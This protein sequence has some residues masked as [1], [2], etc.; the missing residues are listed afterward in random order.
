MLQGLSGVGWLALVSG[1]TLKSSDR[2]ELLEAKNREALGGGGPE[3]IARQHERGKLT[4]RER[5]EL[6]LDP[7]SFVELDR[8]VVHQCDDFGMERNKS[9]GDG[10]ISGYGSVDGRKVFVYSQDFT[11]LGG[12]LGA[13]HAAKIVKILDLALKV[14]AP[15]IGLCDSG[16]ARIQEGVASLG[17]YA[18]I[19]YRN[20]LASGVVPQLSVILGPSAGG[21]VYSPALT[22]FVF[23]V[24]GTS[25]M[26]ITGPDVIKAV[27]HEQVD[28][29]EL[30]GA[31]THSTKS[32]VCHF[33]MPDEESC[34]RAVR[35]L[36]SFLPSNNAEDP[37]ASVVKDSPNRLVHE[38][39]DFVPD[40]SH[41]PY[42]MVE[43]IRKLVDDKEVFLVHERFARNIVT[44]FARIG[45]R[46]VGIVANQPSHLA[47]VLDVDASVKAARFVRVCDCFNVPLITFV[48]VP[49][50]LPGVDQEHSGIIKHGAKLLYA[51]SEATVPKLTVIVRK[52]YGGAYDVMSSKHIGAD[53]N[54]AF[55]SAE[56]AVMGPGGA[57]NIIFR[58]EIQHAEDPDARR[59]E[60]VEA[61]RERFASP[62]KAAELGFIDEV[63]RPR[64]VR[65][66]LHAALSL[67]K[68]K[69]EQLPRKKH[70]NVPL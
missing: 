20:T 48:D 18:D 24:E 65:R 38:L 31:D 16:G 60:L 4:A 19:F 2:L 29:E 68:N 56:I 25:Y 11:V 59:D 53:T 10:V 34:M 47:G 9:L 21:A 13:A 66:R 28:K 41:E 70:G 43:L 3:Q 52:A 57:T 37:P 45:G 12:S 67:L 62:Y 58:R 26:F 46:P 49:G 33:G 64:D 69:R 6:L 61:Y 23:M 35:K 5:L 7:D 15:V 32:G 54:L 27:T 63:I 17:G 50:F 14:G 36:L 1:M 39:D 8:F 30:G 44:A 40:D 55:P 51:Y 22:D 42:D